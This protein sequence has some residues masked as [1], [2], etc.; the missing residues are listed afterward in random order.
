MTIGACAA[1][2]AQAAKIWHNTIIDD[3][4][5][6]LKYIMAI[7]ACA[8]PNKRAAQEEAA[9]PPVR[10]RGRGPPAGSPAR[11]PISNSQRSN[12]WR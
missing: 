2:A 4:I 9:A 10:W 6:I 5:L 1:Q 8:A 12:C 3:M 11:G 7:A